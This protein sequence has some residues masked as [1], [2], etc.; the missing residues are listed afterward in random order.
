MDFGAFEHVTF[1][2]RRDFHHGKGLAAIKSSARFWIG[3]GTDSHS[4]GTTSI[5]CLHDPAAQLAE[6]VIDYCDRNLAQDLI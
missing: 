4:H 3:V 6:I 1:C 5:Q 2:S